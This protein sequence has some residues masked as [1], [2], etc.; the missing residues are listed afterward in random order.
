VNTALTQHFRPEFLN[1]VDETIIFHGLSREQIGQIV[2]IQL[3][4]LRKRLAERKMALTLT[5][6]AKQFLAAEGYDP[7]YGARPLKRVIQKRLLDQ[8]SLKLLNGEVRDGDQL[9]V[10]VEGGR[11]SIGK[12]SVTL[13][14]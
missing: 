3:G 11:L 14:A 1:R 12:A 9:L 5:P 8:L 10:D 13:A 7:V 6:N 4:G 2:E